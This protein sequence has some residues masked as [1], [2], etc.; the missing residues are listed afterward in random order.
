LW[1]I[2]QMLDFK[3]KKKRIY[4]HPERGYNEGTNSW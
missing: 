2:D 3:T 4:Q 1:S